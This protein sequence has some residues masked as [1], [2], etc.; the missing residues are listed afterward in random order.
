MVN[1]NNFLKQA[2]DM[3]KK[4]QAMQE[5]M[6]NT[7]YVGKAGGGLISITVTGKGDIRKVEIDPSLLKPEE[8]EMCDHS[9]NYQTLYC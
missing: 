2:Q 4:M 1:F 9:G 7:E 6:G 3:Q 5:Q 8:K